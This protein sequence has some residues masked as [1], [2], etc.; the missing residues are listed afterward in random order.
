MLSTR[1][2]TSV[3]EGGRRGRGGVE[4]VCRSAVAKFALP[5]NREAGHMPPR[6][7]YLNGLQMETMCVL[8]YALYALCVFAGALCVVVSLLVH[9]WL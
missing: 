2:L 8:E 1:F 9:W 6:E 5:H 3:R 7:F 4:Q